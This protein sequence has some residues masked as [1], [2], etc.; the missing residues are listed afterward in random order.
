[1][2]NKWTYESCYNDAKKYKTKKDY[3][4]KSP[5]SYQKAPDLP[6]GS[7]VEQS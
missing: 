4:I 3:R 2:K 1:M 5:S 7:Q 6:C